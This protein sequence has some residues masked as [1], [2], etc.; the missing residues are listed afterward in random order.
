MTTAGRSTAGGAI[1]FLEL[2]IAETTTVS[3]EIDAQ[4]DAELT[5]SAAADDS[6][7]T[8]TR[9]VQ[10]VAWGDAVWDV[11]VWGEA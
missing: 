6:I 7:A 5:E 1:E 8:K 2:A 11:D 4:T 9:D 10:P 3:D